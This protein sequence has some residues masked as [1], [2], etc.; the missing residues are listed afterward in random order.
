MLLRKASVSTVGERGWMVWIP[1]PTPS[2]IE[3]KIGNV[4]VERRESEERGELDACKRH[5]SFV[6]MVLLILMIGVGI[7]VRERSWSRLVDVTS[8]RKIL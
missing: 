6:G 3:W 8:E 1:S 2:V 5:Q 4:T 7:V